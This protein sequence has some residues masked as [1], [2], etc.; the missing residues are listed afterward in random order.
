MSTNTRRWLR[1]GAASAVLY[2]L[3]RVIV[4]LAVDSQDARAVL[5]I[6]SSVLI[7][8]VAAVVLL[9][10]VRSGGT[11]QKYPKSSPPREADPDPDGSPKR[12]SNE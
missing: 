7:A 4:N 11:A 8:G 5:S 2:F 3:L 6:V 1:I 12:L 9:K 10:L